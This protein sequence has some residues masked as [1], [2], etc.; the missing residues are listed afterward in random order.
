MQASAFVRGITAT[1]I[2]WPEP[3]G[4]DALSSGRL[5]NALLE[6]PR[7]EGLVTFPVGFMGV[8]EPC[9]VASASG[10]GGYQASSVCTDALSPRLLQ[11]PV[12]QPCRRAQSVCFV[13][14]CGPV[15]LH[16]RERV[17][18]DRNTQLKLRGTH[19]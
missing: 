5:S 15:G 16:W 12:R 17:R 2:S 4:E 8:G 10:L 1:R 18:P 3:A 14:A 11:P 6:A 7:D 13:C 19:T 9:W